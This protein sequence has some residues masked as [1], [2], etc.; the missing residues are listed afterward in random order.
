MTAGMR[1]SV[2]VRR[3]DD[4]PRSARASATRAMSGIGKDSSSGVPG[5]ADAHS[6][7]YSAA[8]RWI[9]H[10]LGKPSGALIQTGRERPVLD[11]DRA[12]E[13]YERF[14]PPKISD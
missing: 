2:R 6:P 3:L 11:A 8:E 4:E 7:S 5:E 9:P 12:V 13:A 14:C 10:S 1:P